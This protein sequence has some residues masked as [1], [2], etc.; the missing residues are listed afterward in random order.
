MHGRVHA[1]HE[2]GMHGRGCVWQG[3]GGACMAGDVHGRRGMHGRGHAWQ[4]GMRGRGCAWQEEMAT[5]A[6]GTHPTGMHSC[7]KS[8]L[9][10]SRCWS[11]STSHKEMKRK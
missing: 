2:G 10:R 1:W 11:M 6:D 5:A 9:S 3:G 7:L 8:V 4:G